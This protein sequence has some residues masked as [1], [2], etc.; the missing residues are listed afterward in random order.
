MWGPLHLFFFLGLISKLDHF[1]ELGYLSPMEDGG[2]DITNFTTINPRLGTMEDFDELVEETKVR[3]KGYA[4]FAVTI[5]N[6]SLIFPF[7]IL[8]DLK[9]IVDI[10]INHSSDKHRWFIDSINK[11]ENYIDYYVWRDPKAYDFNG[12]PIPPNNWV[13]QKNILILSSISV[14]IYFINF[15]F[16]GK[17]FQRK[18]LAIMTNTEKP[19]DI[20]QNTS[21][22]LPQW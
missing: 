15:V 18:Y 13:S 5:T 4:I 1:L 6:S 17:H 8:S 7:K 12:K 14:K 3:G 2:Y 21:T 22:Y 20:L 11:E 16:K 10:V 9:L 19:W